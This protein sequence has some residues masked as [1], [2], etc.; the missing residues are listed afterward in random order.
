MQL[1]D[2]RLVYSATDLVAFLECRHLANLERAAVL[3]DLKRPFRDDPVLDRLA[4]RGREYEARFLES[5]GAEN[6]A[7]QGNPAAR[8]RVSVPSG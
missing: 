5:L 7:I 4:R 2:R 1:I 8:H 6:L 3:H